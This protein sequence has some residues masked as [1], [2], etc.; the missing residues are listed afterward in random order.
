M[1]QKQEDLRAALVAA[2]IANCIRPKKSGSY[3][4][5]DFM[6]ATDKP[7]NERKPMSEEEMLLMIKVW[8]A[9]LDGGER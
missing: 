3:S 4:P 1:S 7:K 5:E 9:A 6:S 8:N 2:T